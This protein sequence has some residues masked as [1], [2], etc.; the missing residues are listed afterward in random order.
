VTATG[1]DDT[2]FVRY[3]GDDVWVRE[4]VDVGLLVTLQAKARSIRAVVDAILLSAASHSPGAD[5]DAV[6][7]SQLTAILT[8]HVQAKGDAELQLARTVDAFAAER[9]QLQASIERE[10][11]TVV[12]EQT[13]VQESARVV[14]L[15]DTELLV[16]QQELTLAQERVAEL[17]TQVCECSVSPVHVRVRVT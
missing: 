7:L 1:S 6:D 16:L 5:I 9:S 17:E 15:R 10:Q 14:Q 13:R 12:V 3:T 4:Y 8:S 2:R 11:A